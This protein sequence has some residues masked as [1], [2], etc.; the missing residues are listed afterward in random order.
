MAAAGLGDGQPGDLTPLLNFFLETGITF[1]AAGMDM[2]TDG[3][4]GSRFVAARDL[5]RDELL[6]GRRRSC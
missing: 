3:G 2:V 1:S 5:P 6:A 4:E